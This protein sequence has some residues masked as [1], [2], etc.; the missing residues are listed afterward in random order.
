MLSEEKSPEAKILF[1]NQRSPAEHGSTAP[2]RGLP[3]TPSLL[4]VA[5]CQLPP[6]LL[7]QNRFLH[8][9]LVKNKGLIRGS[10]T[11]FPKTATFGREGSV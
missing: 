7:W 5:D 9:K 4:M 3:H 1:T 2:S 11:K 10:R 8:Y 6:M